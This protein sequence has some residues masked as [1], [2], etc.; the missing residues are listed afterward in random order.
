[1][2]TGTNP[3][4]VDCCLRVGGGFSAGDRVWIVE[5]LLVLA[6][7]VLDVAVFDGG[8]GVT[9]LHV[10]QESESAVALEE[11][12]AEGVRLDMQILDDEGFVDDAGSAVRVQ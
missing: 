5:H 2:S 11:V 12:A 4:T 6:Y 8:F 9:L 3:A 1:M 10:N 7:E